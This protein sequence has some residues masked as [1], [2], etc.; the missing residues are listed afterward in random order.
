MAAINAVA[1]DPRRRAAS[2][3]RLVACLNDRHDFVRSAAV[4]QLIDEPE[5]LPALRDFL[6]ASDTTW[7]EFAS[8]RVIEKLAGDLKARPAI[9]ACLENPGISLTTS[10]LQKLAQDPGW[11]PQIQRRLDYNPPDPEA[12]EALSGDSASLLRLRALL[13][14]ERSYVRTSAIVALANDEVAYDRILSMLRS[15][16]E[17][18][19]VRAACVNVIK[20]R[21]DSRKVL[22]ALLSDADQN[23][24]CAAIKALRDDPSAIAY[25][26][27]RLQD[28]KTMVRREAIV[29][30]ARH[31]SLTRETLWAYFSEI[32]GRDSAQGILFSH[33]REI[34]VRVLR[35]DLGSRQRIVAALTDSSY[36]VR[37]AAVEVLMP[38]APDSPLRNVLR[39][40]VDKD[41]SMVGDVA[42][43]A[44]SDEP[45]IRERLRPMLQKDEWRLRLAGFRLLVAQTIPRQ[46]ILT[47]LANGPFGIRVTTIEPLAHVRTIRESL[48]PYLDDPEPIIRGSMVRVLRSDDGAKRHLREALSEGKI[49]AENFDFTLREVAE[50]LADD[51]AAHPLF[52]KLSYSVNHN[53]V[54][55]VVPALANMRDRL[56]AGVLTC[57]TI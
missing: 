39:A 34:V 15:R 48:Y 6:E 9:Q 30:L 38:V 7:T 19:M 8:A 49:T 13:D 36:E 16:K 44:L 51:P 54:A 28:S 17:D 40:L 43:K 52:L 11:R 14:D 26:R 45:A 42:L 20:N 35:D 12:M 47:L 24:R 37:A 27:K 23:V 21:A 41:V 5:A 1:A 29:A 10:T 57:R 3:D 50:T 53:V 4:Y 18:G 22:R 56:G 31:P 55:A 32:E 46:Q 2:L 25:V 33:L